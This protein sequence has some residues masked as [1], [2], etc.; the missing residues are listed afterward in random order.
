[1]LYELLPWR[2]TIFAIINFYIVLLLF[3]L[4]PI[5]S[6]SIVFYVDKLF[7][8]NLDKVERLHT[9]MVEPNKWK[10]TSTGDLVEEDEE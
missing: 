2:G 7:S 3:S 8:M 4:L 5:T 10:I 1:M 9:T 6:S